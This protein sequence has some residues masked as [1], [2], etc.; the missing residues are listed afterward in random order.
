MHCCT[1]CVQEVIT[2]HSDIVTSPIV[3]EPNPVVS[4][5]SLA[6][7]QVATHV[8]ATMGHVPTAKKNT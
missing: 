2:C 7:G 3:L 5:L 8:T 1:L 6:I 4:R